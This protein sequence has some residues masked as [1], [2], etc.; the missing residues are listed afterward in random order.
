MVSDKVMMD[1]ALKLDARTAELTKKL[2]KANQELNRFRKKTEKQ[3]SGLSS[4]FKTLAGTVAATFAVSKLTGFGKELIQIAADTEGVETAFKN[5]NDP[6]LL[7]ELREATMGTVSDLELMK[8]SLA[9]KNFK[10]PL[11]DLAT[12]MKFA[13]QRATETGESVDYLVNSIVT[14]LGRK[15]VMILDNLGISA[16]E[17]KEKMKG[18]KDMAAALGEVINENL[19]DDFTKTNA[20]NLATISAQWDNIKAK[21]G[22]TLLEGVGPMIKAT[23]DLL[24]RQKALSKELSNEHQQLNLLVGVATSENIT[25]ETRLATIKELNTEYPDLLSSYD[26]EKITN[27]ELIG[28]LDQVNEKY[29]E[30]IKLALIQEELDKEESHLS[31]LMKREKTLNEKL[32]DAQEKLEVAR[33]SEGKGNE[34]MDAI[35][36]SQEDRVKNLEDRIDR[37]QGKQEEVRDGIFKSVDALVQQKK[38]VDE[39][40]GS[41]EDEVVV[42]GEVTEQLGIIKQV[43]QDIL[44]L[45]EKK[46]GATEEE[47]GLLNDQIKAKQ[48]EL[49]RLNDLSAEAQLKK[50]GSISPSLSSTLPRINFDEIKAIDYTEPAREYATAWRQAFED[51]TRF[52][53]EALRAGEMTT[54]EYLD[55]EKDAIGELTS[56]RLNATSEWLDV[57]RQAA[58]SIATLIEAQ[59]QRELSA[60]G[61]NAKKREEI[62]KEYYRK[63]KAMAIISAIIN[64]AVGVTKAFAQGGI[65][66]YVTGALVAVAT[67]AQI[68]LIASQKFTDGGIAGIVPGTSYTGDKVLAAVNSGE[69]IINDHQQASLWKAIQTGN[70]GGRK[71]EF[72]ELRFGYDALY[73][74]YQIGAKNYQRA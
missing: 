73:V 33:R 28:V 17:L 31:N 20:N 25:R 15:S 64:G 13:T 21:M 2:D 7:R 53:R 67:G 12:Y 16:S 41:S 54:Q 65:L 50:G 1:I 18:G 26:T 36:K 74:G 47:L 10:I 52:A 62:E 5:L 46:N 29:I 72:G 34:A 51:K 43:Q 63:Q 6:N 70:F 4:G 58:E 27:E 8:V 55:V 35:I 68:A 19:S 9:A 42:T 39:I 60:V 56:A 23:G 59:K 37:N 30:R 71:V 3:L 11:D 66:G 49:K 40:V 44:D 14:G 61:N 22:E 69:M 24:L 45:Q 32:I 57:T 38:V 48:E